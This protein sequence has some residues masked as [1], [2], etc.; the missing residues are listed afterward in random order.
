MQVSDFLIIYLSIGAPILVA[1]IV[2]K[3]CTKSLSS[4]AYAVAVLTLWPLFACLL[5][6][7]KYRRKLKHMGSDD[8]LSRTQ[9]RNSYRIHIIQNKIEK[10]IRSGHRPSEIYRW[11]SDF[12]R[13]VNV[14]L[15][16]SDDAQT[17]G[18]F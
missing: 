8:S 13:Y 5:L 12:D 7:Q 15:S 11:R 16:L 9:T 1:Y 6:Y 14:L 3:R 17:A 2:T 4:V 18:S 10:I